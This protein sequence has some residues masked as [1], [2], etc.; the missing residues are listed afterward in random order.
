MRRYSY[1][2][3]GNNERLQAAL[4]EGTKIRRRRQYSVNIQMTAIAWLLEFSSGVI[5]TVLQYSDVP[6]PMVFLI[7]MFDIFIN[8]VIIPGFY[9]LN[10]DGCRGAIVNRGWWQGLK[11]LFG[12]TKKEQQ[13]KDHGSGNTVAHRR[14]SGNTERSL[15][16]NSR[17]CR[18]NVAETLTERSS[19]D[20]ESTSRD[21]E[22]AAQ[23]TQE[24][25]IGRTSGSHSSYAADEVHRVA[26][27]EEN[28]ENIETIVL[29]EVSPV[30]ANTRGTC[31]ISLTMPLNSLIC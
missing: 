23:N 31:N 7:G 16:R 19:S 15:K 9:T 13:R 28:N 17:D 29:H 18:E 1:Y 2:R 22:N 11:G 5:V 6:I 21:T 3:A 30:T 27:F 25:R 8:F 24:R 14:T 26:S 10:T 12:F 4:S 20:I